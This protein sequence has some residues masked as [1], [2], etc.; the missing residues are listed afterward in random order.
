MQNLM[1]PTFADVDFRTWR[2]SWEQQVAE[3]DRVASCPVQMCMR[4]AAVIDAISPAVKQLKLVSVRIQDY[5]TSIG[6]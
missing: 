2:M 3:R 6:S 1:R 4:I 5:A